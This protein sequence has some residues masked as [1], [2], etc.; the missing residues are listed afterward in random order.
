MIAAGSIS[1]M[2]MER[3][4]T[5]NAAT[6]RSR[7]WE[8]SLNET[9]AADCRTTE[10]QVSYEQ[11]EPHHLFAPDRA[12]G[13]QLWPGGWTPFLTE[14]RRHDHHALVAGV[15]GSTAARA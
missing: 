1:T 2:A 4:S 13:D 10:L 6:R 14:L 5:R 11:T 9:S 12:A 7:V 15:R 8:L 3:A